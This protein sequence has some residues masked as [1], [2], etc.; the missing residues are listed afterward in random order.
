MA[1]PLLSAWGMATAAATAGAGNTIR[2]AIL[3]EAKQRFEGVYS[4]ESLLD[5]PKTRDG[6]TLRITKKGYPCGGDKIPMTFGEFNVS[7]ATSLDVFNVLANVGHQQKWDSLVG[8]E[9]TLGDFEGQRA[10]GVEMAFVAHPFSDREVFEWQAFNASSDFTDLWVVFSTNHNKD[11]HNKKGR[12][13]GATAA[14][15][16]LAAYHISAKPDG[17]VHILFTSQVNAHPFLLSSSFIFNI[18]WGKTVDYINAL[19]TEAQKEAKQRPAGEATKS[20]VPQSLLFD[21]K[22]DASGGCPAGSGLA[23]LVEVE[24]VEVP[25]PQ[26]Q[27]QRRLAVTF[28]IL[29]PTFLAFFVGAIACGLR[30]L[31][32]KASRDLGA[33]VARAEI[34]PHELEKGPEGQRLLLA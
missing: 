14:Q 10:R 32:A 21:D 22:S 34:N 5:W 12:E 9:D 3:C 29:F 23:S 8:Q 1:L 2:E 25:V 16:C 28:V 13:S 26:A 30:G 4:D 27:R 17:H 19:R 11:L 24:G 33:R 7:G 31:R 15:D 6:V 20:M 18:M